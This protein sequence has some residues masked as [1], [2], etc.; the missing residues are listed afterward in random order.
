M[1]QEKANSKLEYITFLQIVGPILVIL[2]HMT[3][4]MPENAVLHSIKNFIYVF[5]MPLFFFISGYLFAYKKGL[6]G[7]QYGNFIKKKAWRL[8]LPYFVFNIIFLF[9]K[10]LVSNFIVDK[11]EISLGYFLSILLTPRLN[12]WGHLWFLFALFILFVFAPLWDFIIKKNKKIIWII[13]FILL[14]LFNLFPINTD[15]LAIRDLCKDT[16]FFVLG[17]F[18]ATLGQDKI[19]AICTKRNIVLMLVLYVIFFIL[20]NIFDSNI[21]TMFLCTADILLLFVLPITIQLF[22]EKKS[23]AKIDEKFGGLRKVWRKISKL[24]DYSFSIYIMHWPVMLT[25]RIVLY[26][27]LHWNPVLVSFLMVL[28]GYIMPLLIIKIIKKIKEKMHIQ[29]KILYYLIGV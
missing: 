12:V 2:G 8:L 9:P 10:L 17:M 1:E 18:L 29:S 19:K 24:G 20:W 4:G 7:K 3:N 13:T 5:H 14:L 23:K 25:I 21:T 6:K 11:V 26:Q 28:G 16:L 27:I 22:Y 15:V